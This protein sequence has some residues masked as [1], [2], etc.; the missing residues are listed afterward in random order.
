MSDIKWGVCVGENDDLEIVRVFNNR[1][2]AVQ[3]ALFATHETQVIHTVKPVEKKI[4]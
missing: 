3:D 2:A 1:D 4:K